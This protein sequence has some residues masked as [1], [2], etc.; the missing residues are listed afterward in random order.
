MESIHEACSTPSS[1]RQQ[2]RQGQRLPNEC[3][4]LIVEH[5]HQDLPTLR[6]L[7]LVNKFLFHATIPYLYN[8]PIATWEMRNTSSYNK[9]FA[10]FFISFL[11]VRL[12]ELR[13]DSVDDQE[14]HIILDSILRQYGLRL[15]LPFQS[16]GLDM[17]DIIANRFDE[18]N[19]N[20]N[21]ISNRWKDSAQRF[22]IDY[23]K[24]LSDL[25]PDDWRFLQFYAMVRLRKLPKGMASVYEDDVSAEED[26]VNESLESAVT[27][28]GEVASAVES[29]RDNGNNEIR[30]QGANLDHYEDRDEDGEHSLDLQRRHAYTR[31]LRWALA[32]MWLHCNFDS[33]TSFYFEMVDAHIYLP[34]ASKMAKIELLYLNRETTMS[35]SHLENTIQFIMKNQEAFPRKQPLDVMLYNGWYYYDEDEDDFNIA[36]IDLDSHKA[37]CRKR[38]QAMSRYM[39]PATTIYNAIGKPSMLQIGNIPYFYEDAKNIKL[40]RLKEFADDDL[41]RMDFGEGSDRE[42]FLRRC[43]NLRKLTL[44]VGSPDVFSWMLDEIKHMTPASTGRPLGKLESLELSADY[45]YNSAI[46]VFNDAMIAFS[47][48]LRTIDLRV[49]GKLRDYSTPIAVKNSRTMKSL[50]LHLLASATSIGEWPS[51]LPCLTVIKVYLVDVVTINIGSLEQ[52]P[53]LEILE[54][55]FGVKHELRCRPE[56]IAPSAIPEPG[57]LLD[58]RWVQ[59]ELD[60]SLFSVWNLP[61]LKKLDLRGMAALKFNFRSLA[62]MQRL[63]TLSINAEHETLLEKNSALYIERQQKSLRLQSHTSS[64]NNP[65][66]MNGT[67]D[68]NSKKIWELPELQTIYMSGPPS[69]MFC[70]DFLRSL[71]K[72]EVISLNGAFAS[73]EIKRRGMLGSYNTICIEDTVFTEKNLRDDDTNDERPYFESHLKK[74]SLLGGWSISAQDTT[75]LLTI[76]APFLEEFIMGRFDR[77]IIRNGFKFLQ[78]MKDADD[79]NEAYVTEEDHNLEA[80]ILKRSQRLIPGQNLTTISFDYKLK[81]QDHHR[82]GLRHITK[83]VKSICDSYCLRTYRLLNKYLMRQTDYELIKEKLKEILIDDME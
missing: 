78:A 50:Q 25:T 57:E 54:I 30:P 13:P 47:S 23:S 66:Q 46:Q 26:D 73:Q 33:I 16:S 4:Y 19:L 74:V 64:D 80:R 11:Q 75:S 83:Q 10:L 65:R 14:A 40:E 9:L 2:L 24:F 12:E 61:K 60:F 76:Y 17:L 7:I 58:L 39:K 77:S 82:L 51:L 18:S 62:G 42:E 37:K 5:L 81:K 1:S 38:R 71:P 53:N 20:N 35:D 22:T 28:T 69:A 67:F 79:I 56:G 49:R 59:G 34:L 41:E 6:N 63:T 27:T 32:D 15:T 31:P 55:H 3:L 52:C 48:S 36:L 43:D 72:L 45:S 70:L 21:F 8:N 44:A 29:I 68:S